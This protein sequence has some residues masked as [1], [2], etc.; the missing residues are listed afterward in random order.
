MAINLLNIEEYII[1]RIKEVAPDI[2][3]G[4]GSAIRDLLVSPMITVLQ[5]L[6]NEIHRVKKTQSL[7]NA[8]DLS[9]DDLDAIL[10]NI[11]IDRLVGSK[12]RGTAKIFLSTAEI[13]TIPEGTLFFA[14]GGL[15]FYSTQTI[16]RGPATLG[17][18]LN[19]G[20]YE[21]EIPL[22]AAEQG[23]EY[24]ISAQQITGIVSS[25]SVIVGASNDT[26][27][28][29]GSERESSVNLLDR[30][31]AGLGSR[32][33]STKR[34]ALSILQERFIDIV[35]V[36][37]I[38]FGNK[39]MIRDT[40]YAPNLTIDGIE[41]GISDGVHIGGKVD[42]YI[43]VGKTIKDAT[44]ANLN[45]GGSTYGLNR[46]AFYTGGTDPNIKY[47]EADSDCLE[48]D[49]PLV[50]I[51]SISLDED[52]ADL[53]NFNSVS[54]V[55]GKNVI[56]FT[57]SP[58]QNNSMDEKKELRFIKGSGIIENATLNSQYDSSPGYYYP[59]DSY[60][61]TMFLG[62][63]DLRG[64]E[65]LKFEGVN[66]EEL[67]NLD[68]F[69]NPSTDGGGSLKFRPSHGQ[70]EVLDINGDEY[71]TRV[72]HLSTGEGSTITGNLGNSQFTLMGWFNITSIS[73]ERNTLFNSFNGV[74]DVL[75]IYIDNLGHIHY[76][77][78]SQNGGPQD[79]KTKLPVLFDYVNANE[80]DDKWVYLAFTY[81]KSNNRKNI[82]YAN[83]QDTDLTMA[84]WETDTY[85]ISTLKYMPNITIGTS[86]DFE[87]NLLRT[88]TGLIDAMQIYDQ[89]VLDI[90]QLESIRKN[91]NTLTI[92]GLENTTIPGE[93]ATSLAQWPNSFTF[94]GGR[95]CMINGLA[96]GSYY[97]IISSD[98]SR[99]TDDVVQ[100]IKI[101]ITGT[102]GTPVDRIKTGD[103]YALTPKPFSLEGSLVMED[104]ANNI[105]ANS[106]LTEEKEEKIGV[107]VQLV[108]EAGLGVEDAHSY[109]NL[110][111]T[112]PANA[113]LLVKHAIPIKVSGEISIPAEVGISEEEIRLA[114]ADYAKAIPTGGTFNVIGAL[115]YVS[116]YGVVGVSLPLDKLVFT[117]RDTYFAP[118]TVLGIEDFINANENQYFVVDNTFKVIFT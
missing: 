112:R 56:F 23:I 41:Y 87:N 11:F 100:T 44:K 26:A 37:S 30:A 12:A 61:Y 13:I 97:D 38:G 52:S 62:T 58:G 68:I 104:L 114:F 84:Q 99:D 24:N 71:T 60:N 118:N 39:E 110:H 72:M 101:T 83:I 113:D 36:N 89:N 34:G 82:Y 16:T 19:T 21:I 64:G 111:D 74:E 96:S 7:L 33:L 88:F 90:S 43:R 47:E 55:E 46:L 85:N 53:P 63:K 2:N 73:N 65:S 10:A 107:G 117:S 5:P 6:A 22:E 94:T 78:I 35:D 95:I 109:V 102:S 105:I 49:T 14:K 59:L 106:Y 45:S 86:K 70:G 17:L 40:I 66:A 28:T 48:T 8:T 80:A 42:I 3:T 108:Y 57:P 50:G 98:I 18:N 67:D 116:D 51:R 20:R 32:D 75:D 25:N 91:Q 31:K 27:F 79:N 76:N 81:D 92:D 29:G 103:T 77:T 93:L 1:Q 115:T 4:T 54:L 15:K 9:D 69:N